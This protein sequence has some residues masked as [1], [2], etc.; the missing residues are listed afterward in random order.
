M[1]KKFIMNNDI[2]N[3]YIKDFDLTFKNEYNA[4]IIEVEKFIEK[5]RILIYNITNTYIEKLDMTKC[6]DFTDRIKICFDASEVTKYR[7]L[8]E[9]E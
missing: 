4:D 3:S 7:M 6:I 5:Y 8:T 1:N 9:I 2:I